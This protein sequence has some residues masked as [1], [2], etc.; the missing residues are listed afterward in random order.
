MYK[1]T[2]IRTSYELARVRQMKE[3]APAI[4][5][6]WLLFQKG[7]KKHPI[8]LEVDMGTETL[9]KFKR[10]VAARIAFIQDGK[11]QAV[12]GMQAVLIAYLAVGEAAQERQATMNS[13]TQEVLADLGLSRW[14]GIFKFT[15]TRTED[16]YTLRLFTE[17]LWSDGGGQ[18]GVR[19]L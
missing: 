8:L 16:I 7:E 9:Q 12:F 3:A 14:A 6:A 17:A 10:H 5:D 18:E 19:L 4:P 1:L 15:G 13:W 2:D 11:Y